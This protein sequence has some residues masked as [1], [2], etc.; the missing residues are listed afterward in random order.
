[1]CLLDAEDYS[2]LPVRQYE[3]DNV[4]RELNKAYLGFRHPLATTTARKATSG[5]MEERL[6][7]VGASR[8]SSPSR[9]N[10]LPAVVENQ[11]SSSSVRE[12]TDPAMVDLSR[13]A[14]LVGSCDPSRRQSEASTISTTATDHDTDNRRSSNPTLLYG[15]GRNAPLTLTNATIVKQAVLPDSSD[16]LRPPPMLAGKK[17]TEGS[18]YASCDSQHG[19][20]SVEEFRSANTSLEE[21]DRPE[22]GKR[23]DG[24][25]TF[26]Y[27]TKKLFYFSNFQRRPTIVRRTKTRC[28]GTSKAR[29]AEPRVRLQLR[30]TTRVPRICFGW[31]RP[32][33]RRF[34]QR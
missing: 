31:T 27:V 10:R 4:L 7:P 25:V 9:S 26:D 13:S 17:S 3:E 34:L 24:T 14:T 23:L 5:G 11:G 2:D 6:P 16:V 30:T 12:E 33:R 15:G 19:N 32:L 29:V 20:S 8:D 1:M 22:S 21:D 28:P 18:I